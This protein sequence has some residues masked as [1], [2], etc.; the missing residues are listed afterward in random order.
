MQQRVSGLFV[1]WISATT[2]HT[3]TRQRSLNPCGSNTHPGMTV[4][5][6]LCL[7]RPWTGAAVSPAT[8]GMVCAGILKVHSESSTL[9]PLAINMQAS[10]L[11]IHTLET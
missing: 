2:M 6:G 7:N 5:I 9:L 3:T 8:Q 1:L 11:V 10:N 4:H